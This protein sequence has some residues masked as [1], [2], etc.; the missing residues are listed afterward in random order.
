MR[1]SLLSLSI[2][3]ITLAGC[4][5]TPKQNTQSLN[6][7][8]YHSYEQMMGKQSYA[9]SG[10]MSFHAEAGKMTKPE[11]ASKALGTPPTSDEA[12]L[13]ED[14]SLESQR[15]QILKEL[16]TTTPN[17]P[18]EQ[19]QWMKEGIENPYSTPSKKMSNKA[20]AMPVLMAS[21]MN[22]YFYE[23]DGVVDLKRG[24]MSFDPTIG[25]RAKN[26][27]A[28]IKLPL[29]LDF[30][31]YKAYADISALSPIL[32]DPQY[33]GQYVVYD[34]KK[35]MDKTDID[36][37]PALEV[38]REMMLVN[39]ALAEESEYQRLPLTA[40]DKQNQAVERIQYKGDYAKMLAQYMLYFYVNQDYLKTL[41]DKNLKSDQPITP[42][43]LFSLGKKSSYGQT[44][45]TQNIA[46]EPSEQARDAMYR[47]YDGI[48]AI[49]A[50]T[51]L[52]K[53][54]APA[55]EQIVAPPPALA[56]DMPSVESYD[57]ELRDEVL[58][59]DE[60]SGEE[61]SGDDLSGEE[62]SEYQI[63]REENKALLAKFDQYKKA[64][65]LITAKELKRIVAEQPEA[66]QVLIKQGDAEFSDLKL[67]EDMGYVTNFSL[68]AEGRLK[69]AE[70]LIEMPNFD[71]IGIKNMTAKAVM[72]IGN[73]GTARVD[74]SKLRNA[75]TFQEAANERSV[76]NLGKIVEQFT[77]DP[78]DSQKG[79]AKDAESRSKYWSRTER[80]DQLAKSFWQQGL[81][82]VEVYS[83]LYNYAAIA[84]LKESDR[85]AFD[86]SAL[87]TTAKWT[88]YYYAD[89]EGFPLTA[90]QKAE[91]DQTPDDWP[92]YDEY[93]AENVWYSVQKTEKEAK[94][95]TDFQKLRK[96]G[97][98]NLQIFETLY[99]LMDEKSGYNQYLTDEEMD[100]HQRFMH[101]IAEIAVED[102]ITQKV[103]VNKLRPYSEAALNRFS[104][105][106][107]RAVYEV[108]LTQ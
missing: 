102:L 70:L 68:D 11:I 2:L 42:D 93:L 7:K 20:Q 71:E 89:E 97:K 45:G 59:G 24:Q 63:R 104:S 13:A 14:V 79:E 82:F 21:F 23:F 1:A 38:V 84:E 78:K 94:L 90:A 107:Y 37:K 4:A 83:A 95:V 60:L 33:D 85:E 32:T 69:R 55:V 56:K 67:L 53:D 15:E 8:V 43:Q 65:Q 54:S 81:S 58:N 61:L 44:L 72:N 31:N 52:A 46:K 16:L 103:D 40:E 87:K 101:T 80:Y 50:E 77:A 17:Y 91:Y 98:T 76:L 47:V 49:Y 74:Q 5:T 30:A 96:Q 105:E 108:F 10:H 35:L 36:L 99:K 106:N 6:E 3:T 29:A 100:E 9:F 18:S 86:L 22:R 48:D 39:A 75:V 26:L 12:T 27:Q 57:D 19:Q 66:Y 62:K 28:W 64:D 92:Y 73:Y 88:A 25:Y 34:F 41:V 51:D